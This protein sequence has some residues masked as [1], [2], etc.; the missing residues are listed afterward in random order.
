MQ[1]FDCAVVGA[2]MVGATTALA[3]ADLGL[4]VVLI[5]KQA[6]AAYS[7][8]QRY[9]LRVSAIS[10][11][12]EQLLR[13][14]NIWPALSAW[15]LCP[16]KR[17]G[18]WEM[19]QAYTEFNADEINQSHLGHIVENRLLQLAAWQQIEQQKNITLLCPEN[20]S[21][22]TEQEHGVV[23]SLSSE[24]IFAKFVVAADG[25]NSQ[26]RQMAGIGITGWDY[27][28][29][30]ML[31]HVETELP[32]Q[33]ITW[34]QFFT[35]G[36]VAMLPLTGNNASLVWYHS[37][38]EIKRLSALSNHQLTNEIMQH[39]PNKLGAVKVIDKASFPL[40]RRHANQYV[41][42]HIVLLGDAAHTINPLAGQGVNLGFKDVKALQLALA[43]TKG[44]FLADNL[45][46]ALTVYEKSRRT[47]NLL[48]MSTMDV[49][50]HSFS[51]HSPLMKGIRNLAI[52]AAGKTPLLKTKALAYAC[53]LA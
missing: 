1:K 16:Y 9:D 19:A 15:R 41:K 6:P 5:D 23:L 12:S 49:L 45:A 38:D 4:T 27:Q 42:K 22:L 3:L 8:E 25:A 52:F 34:Q 47:D 33:D 36:P 40:T 17:L 20:I 53:G 39:F 51:H 28:Q 2:G 18:V 26:I 48:M 50:Y 30:A 29:S 11:A 35:T 10:L 14:L 21:A 13:Q 37:N 46:K 32:Q 44:E 24:A 7:P 31:I 43:E